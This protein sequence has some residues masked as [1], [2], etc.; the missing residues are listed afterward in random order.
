VTLPGIPFLGCKVQSNVKVLCLESLIHAHVLVPTGDRPDHV[1]R[2]D[3]CIQ[4]WWHAEA[5]TFRTCFETS[6][7][8]DAN[9]FLAAGL[10]QAV[11]FEILL[12]TDDWSGATDADA[13]LGRFALPASTVTDVGTTAT[14]GIT[15]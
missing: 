4:S 5:I 12:E 11:S 2:P 7:S 14:C 9:I 6:L 15:S 8:L 3:V 1:P 10:S 13:G